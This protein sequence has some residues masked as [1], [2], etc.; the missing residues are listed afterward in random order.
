MN[1]FPG[2][3]LCPRQHRLGV[4]QFGPVPVLFQDAPAT[5]DG[6]VFAVVRRK[7]QQANG[8]ADVIRELNHP[9]EKL[10]APTIALGPVI[11]LDLHV[12][13]LC[14]QLGRLTL[15]PG[16]ET[17]ND[18]IARLGRAAE[19]QMQLPTGFIDDAKRGVLL[20]APH[21]VVGCLVIAP[22]LAAPRVLANIDRRLAVDAQANDG[23]ALA[24]ALV[25]FDIG[26]DGVGFWDFFWGLALSTGRSR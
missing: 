9:L 17:I 13:D 7:V 25:V 22:R 14:A 19:A 16:V 26:E 11:R 1:A 10:R 3:A 24:S 8:L 12:C 6:I 4:R 20:L 15:P 23:F 18:E 2:H 5:L 21:I